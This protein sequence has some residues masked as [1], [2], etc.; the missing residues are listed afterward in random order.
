MSWICWFIP[1][2]ALLLGCQS[3]PHAAVDVSVG[4]QAD[5]SLPYTAGTGYSWSLDREGSNG[6]ARVTVSE[7]GR[8]ADQADLPGGPG[9]S[10]WTVEGRAAGTAVLV[11]T[12]RRPWEAD[13]SPAK[14]RRVTVQVQ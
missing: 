1:V 14:T 8:D 12:Y 11:F 6:L 5:I 3:I 7:S 10:R 2:T 13:T 4:G 9:Q